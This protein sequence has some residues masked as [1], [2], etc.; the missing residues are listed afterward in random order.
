[1]KTIWKYSTLV[2]SQF[3]DKIEI[4]MPKNAEILCVQRD[5]KT[6]IPCIWAIVDTDAEKETRYF[7]L[8]GTGIK[9]HS[10]MGIERKYVGTYQYQRGEFVGHLFERLN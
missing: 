2:D 5:G 1:M 8:F 9:I 3:K 7:E 10:D 4:E 6:G